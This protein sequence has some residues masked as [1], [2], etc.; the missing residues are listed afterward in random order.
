M[1]GSHSEHIVVIV[2]F[3]TA[4]PGMLYLSNINASWFLVSVAD[5]GHPIHSCVLCYG[6]L[7]LAEWQ[8]RCCCQFRVVVFSVQLWGSYATV[9]STLFF[10]WGFNTRGCLCTALPLPTLGDGGF[11]F[12][13]RSSG[14]PSIH[15]PLY[16]NICFTWCDLSYLVLISHM[17]S[18][19]PVNQTL[20]ALLLKYQRHIKI[21]CNMQ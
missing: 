3:Q 9:K 17:P 12:S 13:G 1:F 10:D 15:C 6:W 19:R 14:A 5:Y 11:M 4:R 18:T 2:M 20:S 21:Y 8:I 7:N 16:T